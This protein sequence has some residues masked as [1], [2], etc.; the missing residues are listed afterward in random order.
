MFHQ[1]VADRLGLNPTDHKCADLLT[2]MGPLTAGELA[3]LTGL[4][5]GAITGVIDRLEGVGFVR[6][7]EDPL[8]RRR[9]IVR[10]LPK[11]HREAGRLF[12][13]LAAAMAELS[14][15]YSDR[16]L[17]AVLDFM[18]RSRQALHEDRKSVV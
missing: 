2:L 14:A 6:R 1:A 15:R 3:D 18:S 13:S 17:A 11:C 5:T 8:D 7:E 10:V 16:E 9:V 12:T 4:T